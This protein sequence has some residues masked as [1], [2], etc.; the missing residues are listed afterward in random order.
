[1]VSPVHRLI[2]G[3]FRD[4][5]TFEDIMVFSHSLCLAHLPTAGHTHPGRDQPLFSMMVQIYKNVEDSSNPY[6]YQ[7]E[8]VGILLTVRATCRFSLS[9]CSSWYQE[10]V[11]REVRK[12]IDNRISFLRLERE[13]ERRHRELGCMCGGCPLVWLEQGWICPFAFRAHRAGMEFTW[14]RPAASAGRVRPAE[15]A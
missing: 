15:Q 2:D 12:L 11:I 13:R 8:Q 6:V 4:D 7:G 5:T 14:S 10:T 9:Y 3:V 1:M